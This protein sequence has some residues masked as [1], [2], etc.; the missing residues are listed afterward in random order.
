M[1]TARDPEKVLTSMHARWN[2]ITLPEIGFEELHTL[3]KRVADRDGNAPP[4]IDSD[5]MLGSAETGMRV[6]CNAIGIPFIP[7]AMNWE[8]RDENPTWNSDEHGFHDALRASTSL[9]KQPRNYPPLQSSTDMMR[10][11]EASK[12]HYDALYEQRLCVKSPAET[13][14]G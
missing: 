6:Y 5:E 3:F 8:Q 4:V 9:K 1:T 14:A 7:A 2:D 12:P 11:Y 13:S 10:L